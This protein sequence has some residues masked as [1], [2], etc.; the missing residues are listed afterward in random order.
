MRGV[1]LAVAALLALTAAAPVAAAEDQ[2]ALW[3]YEGGWYQ[4]KEGKTWIEVNPDIYKDGGRV[5]YVEVRRTK[6]FVELYD[7]GR[8]MAVR[9]YDCAEEHCVG[10]GEWV[11]G[12]AGRWRK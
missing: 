7:E 12:Y 6:Q 9:L 4:R 1:L 5:R 3:V 10:E 2:R 8:K 11:T